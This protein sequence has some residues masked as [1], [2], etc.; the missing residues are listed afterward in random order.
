MKKSIAINIKKTTVLLMIFTISFML[1]GCWNYRETGDLWMVAG[2]AIDL[3][4]DDNKYVLTTEIVKPTVGKD[5]QMISQ[6]I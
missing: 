5:V 4:R 6:T 2:A 1:V 3:D